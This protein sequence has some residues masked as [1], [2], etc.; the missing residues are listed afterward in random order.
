VTTL[1]DFFEWVKAGIRASYDPVRDTY[2]FGGYLYAGDFFRAKILPRIWPD[3]PPSTKPPI[4]QP[5]KTP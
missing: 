1:N 3:L 2:K 4:P 5:E